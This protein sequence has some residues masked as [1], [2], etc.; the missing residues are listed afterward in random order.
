MQ[1]HQPSATENP[2]LDAWLER[3]T[4][5]LSKP[6]ATWLA[7]MSGEAAAA[8]DL[9]SQDLTGVNDVVIADAGNIGSVNDTDAIAISA[10]GIIDFTAQSGVTAYLSANQ[11]VNPGTAVIIEFDSEEGGDHQSEFNTGTYTWTADAAGTYQVSLIVA[12]AEALADAKIL[13]ARIYKN[14]SKY[15][16]GISHSTVAAAAASGVS[17]RM[18]LAAT[19]TISGYIY[20]NHTE[21]REISAGYSKLTIAKIA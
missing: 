7:D 3:L 6:Y 8:F 2:V 14:N 9:N 16:Q 5:Q 10:T 21:A 1:I 4:H 15:L 11:D 13:Q 12:L 19:D 17:T 18:V 20:H